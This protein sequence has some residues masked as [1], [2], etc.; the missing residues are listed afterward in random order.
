MTK[1]FEG[2]VLI[3]TGAASGMGYL[4]CEEY[5]RRGGSAVMADI[6]PESLEAAVSK[7][8]AIRKGSAIG[9]VCDVRD[10]AQICHVRDEAMRVYGRIDLAIPFA[11]GNEIRMLHVD[12]TLDTPEIPIDVYDWSIDVN[13]KGQ[14]YLDH[15]VLGV[16]RDQKSGLLV[17][18]G[19]I[20]GEEGG[21]KGFGYATAK[22]GAMY[23]L[24]KSMAQYGE[25]HGIRCVCVSPGP[26][27]TRDAM[28]GMRTM[29][30]R[31]AEPI[32]IIDVI[33]FIASDKGGFINGTNIMV[34]GGRNA[35]GRKDYQKK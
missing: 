25:K 14:M 23:G 21:G 34:D 20:T 10:Y 9:V 16:M 35:L 11:G 8:N 31:A 13:L 30:G 6:N 5:V 2:K 3:A 15:A 18:I 4:C 17:H 1:E 28:A 33:L 7:V 32:E 24:T 29:L 19:S 27:M 12:K 22:S 26:V